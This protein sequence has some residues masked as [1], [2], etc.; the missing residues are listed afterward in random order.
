MMSYLEHLEHLRAENDARRRR[1]DNR[2]IL[3]FG[4]L[5]ALATA[6]ILIL[7]WIYFPH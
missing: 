1:D 6:L 5:V 3:G 7:K 2:G 4:V